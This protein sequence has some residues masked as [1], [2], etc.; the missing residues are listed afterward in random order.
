M[1]ANLSKTVLRLLPAC[2]LG[3]WLS[4]AMG[5]AS[6]ANY[7]LQ[8]RPS[9]CVSYDSGEPCVMMLNISWAGGAGEAVCLNTAADAA[10]LTCWN[11]QVAGETELPYEDSGNVVYQLVS[12]QNNRILAEAEVQVIS[13]DLRDSRRRR[14]HVWS[15][16]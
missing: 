15:I 1:R 14:R 6:D 12:M 3:S 8:I 4:V 11:N 13:R 2:V 16:L 9:I 7:E 10:Y 5:A